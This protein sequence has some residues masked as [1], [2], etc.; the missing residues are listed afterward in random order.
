MEK[1]QKIHYVLDRIKQFKVDTKNSPEGNL[2]RQEYRQKYNLERNFNFALTANDIIDGKIPVKVIGCTGLVKL[3]AYYANEI[4]LDC[5][6]VF[7]ANENDLKNKSS[8]INGHQ[9]ISVK[10]E[11]GKEVVFDPQEPELKEINLANFSHAGTPHI[12]VAKQ[13]GKDIEK[14]NS[15]ETLEKIYLDGYKNRFK[16]ELREPEI[17]EKDGEVNT[18][19]NTFFV[20]LDGKK[21]D[22]ITPTNDIIVLNFPGSGMAV[23]R[24]YRKKLYDD[25]LD[26]RVEKC[27]ENAKTASEKT[28]E[29]ISENKV[30]AKFFTAV[31]EYKADLVIDDY[32]TTETPDCDATKDIF[33]KTITPLL[34]D[35]FE[36][37]KAN[38]NKLFLRG[39]CFGTVV[40]S[41]LE[42]LLEEKLKTAFDDKQVEELLHLPKAFISSP[43]LSLEN[44][45]KHFQT[46]A[47]VNISDR[48]IASGEGWRDELKVELEKLTGF[49]RDKRLSLKKTKD[50]IKNENYNL[51]PIETEDISSKLNKDNVKLYVSNRA[52]FPRNFEELKENIKKKTNEEL[53]VKNKNIFSDEAFNVIVD[54]WKYCI[55]ENQKMPENCEDFDKKVKKWLKGHEYFCL[56]KELKDKFE[57]NLKKD[58]NKVQNSNMFDDSTNKLQNLDSPKIFIPNNER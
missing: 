45:P 27:K 55:D 41:Q 17:K 16:F 23:N 37:T 8:Q 7:T 35:D 28:K 52:N 43:A 18:I 2:D 56:P 31:Y 9:L 30:N 38:L 3:F 5:E 1:L 21:V 12:F 40:I 34:S 42:H 26:E 13:L 57:Q 54:S 14:V 10:L 58:F 25:K 50:V 51:V 6:V 32:N 53:K 48:T 22:T 46:T 15:Y 20:D 36:K 19:G 47:I 29:L 4:G 44:Y 33:N 39:H 24:D 49:N 11:N